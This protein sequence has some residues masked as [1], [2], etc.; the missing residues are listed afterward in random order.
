M[1]Q[2]KSDG[3]EKQKKYAGFKIKDFAGAEAAV[4][5]LAAQA[6]VPSAGTSVVVVIG[7]HRYYN[8]FSAQLVECSVSGSGEL[9]NP[10][11]ILNPVDLVWGSSDPDEVRFYTS[12]LKFQNYYE[13]SLTDLVVLKALV[14]N[15]RRYSFYYHD[16][17]ISEKISVRSIS[18]IK[19]SKPELEL[20]VRVSQREETYVITPE[21]YINHAFCAV[22]SVTVRFDHFVVIDDRW[23]LADNPGMLQ[24][25]GWF[26]K[27]ESPLTMAADEFA[28]F[29]TDVL[30]EMETY[31]AI[32]YEYL[33]TATPEQKKNGG[34][35][36]QPE[37]LLYLSD[38]GDYVILE[39]V[40]R[41]GPVEVPILSQRQVFGQ[42]APGKPFLVK[43]DSE[44]ENDFVSLLI[45]QHPD[46]EEQLE[47]PLP[48]FYLHRR[49]FVDDD[50]FFNAFQEWQEQGIST[51]GF[52]ELKGIAVRPQKAHVSI[53]VTSGINWF[54]TE[55]AVHFGTKKATVKQLRKAV[56]NKSKYVQLDDGSKG[57][58][59]EEWLQRFESFF[60][61]G[62]VFG[63][64]LLT[65][66]A[67]FG[68][69]AEL[70]DEHMLTE[71]VKQE[72]KRYQTVFSGSHQLPP[73]QTPDDLLTTLRPYQQQGLSWLNFLD[74]F[75][76][77]GCLADDMGLG[78]TIQ[79]IAF[80]LLLKRKRGA[81]THLLVAPNSVVHNWQQEVARFAPSLKLTVWHGAGR[82]RRKD[83]FAGNDVVI[84]T[85]NTMVADITL[86][87]QF[88]FGY[89]FLDE[90]QNIKNINSQRYRAAKLLKSRNKLVI[91]GTPLENNTFDVYAQLSFACPGL[92]GSIQYFRHTYA[93][94]IDKFKAK[95]SAE[96]LQRRI[97]PFVLRRTKQEV[98]AELPE[99]TEK[100]LY[101]E[102]GIE[103]RRLYE[104]YE[105]EFREYISAKTEEEI[106]KNPM[107]AL[108]GITRLRQICNSPLL[109]GE[110]NMNL[111]AS[112]KI[113]ML[114]DQ[115]S[116]L[117]P[118][119]KVLVFSQFVSMLELIRRELDGENIKH[120]MLTGATKNR[121]EVVHQFQ[122]D[123][124][125]RVFLIS[126]KAGGTGLNLTAA[127]Y[128]FLVDPWWNP[129]VENQ[130]I[131]RCYRIGQKKNVMATRLICP[132]TV[133]EKMQVI[134]QSKASL[135]C[136]LIGSGDS[137]FRLLTKQD[138]LEMTRPS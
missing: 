80:I 25:I 129:A 86:L 20:K 110:E 7:Q 57:V 68:T 108:R 104:A 33:K 23:Y 62:E 6:A 46:F 121:A 84:T 109:I 124:A 136:G 73:A 125:T 29:K 69:L 100:V 13:K 96:G 70:Y 47:N 17:S 30:A 132:N 119:H 138:L 137:F 92:L 114:L 127:D 44:A 4:K 116:I 117:T 11:T 45:R 35:N 58:L 135:A 26:S 113:E 1:E 52:N 67:G 78:K 19:V 97:S 131:D 94:P 102:M 85:Y 115:L 9:K 12:L 60:N 93:R 55:L 71:E 49:R 15:P 50:W 14:K 18:R 5:S 128:V 72:L 22:S 118:R 89:I 36:G 107:H 42:D 2:P 90:S 66:K 54:N 101:C 10:C 43:R 51:L 24:V 88:E 53:H 79:V 111:N 95:S 103:Q 105:K 21:L 82:G 39:P 64:V 63:E 59:P 87:K 41:Y 74:D 126:L 98:A 120:A 61:A 38:L 37:R 28:E 83:T 112:A 48:Y 76:L 123:E 77:G 65:P 40:M 130:A 81:G 133:E 8:R 91:S 31:V 106:Q 32:Q 27:H 134:Q 34:F 99:K 75:N 3:A 56:K 16:S 122:N